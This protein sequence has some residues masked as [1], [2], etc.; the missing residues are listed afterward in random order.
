MILPKT[1][2]Q[3]TTYS[4][5]EFMLE[6]FMVVAGTRVHDPNRSSMGR[7]SFI[8][9]IHANFKLIYRFKLVGTQSVKHWTSINR[10]VNLQ[11][12]ETI[13]SL[14]YLHTRE[15]ENTHILGSTLSANTHVDVIST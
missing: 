9:I 13:Q 4:L 12:E 15:S 5:Y 10:K 2:Y 3:P 11:K 1:E 8:K 6:A 7:S 14:R